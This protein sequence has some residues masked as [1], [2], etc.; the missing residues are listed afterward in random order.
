MKTIENQYEKQANDFL[1]KAKATMQISF[2]KIGPFFSDDKE[3][4]SIYK[5]TIASQNGRY[6]G[7]FGQSVFESQNGTMPTSYDILSCLTKYNPG[8]FENFCGDYGYDT[9]SRKA[10]KTYKAVVKEYEGLSKVFT[11]RQLEE[12]Q[13]I[14]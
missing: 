3:V 9:D 1:K 4:R 13:E 7:K 12:M 8:T 14:Q 6:T 10:E 5:F 2:V 11:T